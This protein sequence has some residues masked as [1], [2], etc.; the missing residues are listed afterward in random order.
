[1]TVRRA[2]DADLQVLEE[3]WR[4][5]ERAV[6]PGTFAGLGLGLAITREIVEAHA[7]TIRVTS[8]PGEGAEFT[9]ELP[10]MDAVS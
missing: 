5:F 1:M 7:G 6:P 8:A 2:R 4:A 3:L 9:V 10:V